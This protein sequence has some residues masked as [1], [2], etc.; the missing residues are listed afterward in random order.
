MK[1]IYEKWHGVMF[2]FVHLSPQAF[3]SW[4]NVHWTKQGDLALTRHEHP[5]VAGV[6]GA[7][8]EIHRTERKL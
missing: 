1:L 8:I 5:G 6:A 4:T 7:A 2:H 3:A